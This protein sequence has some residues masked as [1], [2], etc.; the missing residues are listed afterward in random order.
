M[1]PAED[2]VS[3]RIETRFRKTWRLANL[4]DKSTK[5]G[6]QDRRFDRGGG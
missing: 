6:K 4:P 3:E 5:V 1:A 2:R